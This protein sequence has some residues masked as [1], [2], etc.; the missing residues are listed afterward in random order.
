MAYQYDDAWLPGA[1]GRLRRRLIV[2]K[3]MVELLRHTALFKHNNGE[4]EGLPVI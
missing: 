3:C 1:A 4:P 2:A